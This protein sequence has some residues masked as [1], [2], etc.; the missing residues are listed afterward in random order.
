MPSLLNC[1][2]TGYI[3]T[4]YSTLPQVIYTCRIV[5]LW[6][7]LLP[8]ST[9]FCNYLLKKC[10]IDKFHCIN[11]IEKKKRIVH[12]NLQQIPYLHSP[13]AYLL[14]V[15]RNDS[16]SEAEDRNESTG[17]EVDNINLLVK[18]ARSRYYQKM[19]KNALPMQESLK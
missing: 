4:H 6:L 17:E 1:A 8:T 13:R 3:I 7:F 2:I 10:E 19:E 12:D 5:Y 18:N 15:L 9:H 11:R 14:S 16:A